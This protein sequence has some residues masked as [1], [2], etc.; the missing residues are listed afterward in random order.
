MRRGAV[1]RVRLVV[2]AGGRSRKANHPAT[3]AKTTS[4]PVR[5]PDISASVYVIAQA[6]NPGDFV[7]L[8]QVVP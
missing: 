7:V 4:I 6:W 1:G 3:G 5:K 8:E 2:D